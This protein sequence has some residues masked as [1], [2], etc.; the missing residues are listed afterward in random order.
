MG[1]VI[2]RTIY[3]NGYGCSC[4]RRDWEDTEWIDEEEMINFETLLKETI[5]KFDENAGNG[6]CVGIIYEKDGQ[7]LYGITSTIYR[8]GWEFYAVFGGEAD[9]EY[10]N[11]FLIQNYQGISEEESYSVEE[12]IEKYNSNKISIG[13]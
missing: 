5:K 7:T 10:T 4:C 11:E 3:N 9:H 8:A 13:D 6:G 1:K 12:I 2:K